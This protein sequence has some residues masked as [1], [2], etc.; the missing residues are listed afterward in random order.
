[1]WLRDGP[2]EIEVLE[3]VGVVLIRKLGLLVMH[4]V[5]GRFRGFLAREAR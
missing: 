5:S 3:E 2:V 1:M 4:L